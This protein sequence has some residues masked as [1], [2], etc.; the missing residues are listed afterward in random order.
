MA[1]TNPLTIRYNDSLGTKA[2]PL[3][4]ASLRLVG[5]RNGQ[6]QYLSTMGQLIDA[7][8]KTLDPASHY[9][10]RGH[11]VRPGQARL[12]HSMRVAIWLL[13]PSDG[14]FRRSSSSLQYYLTRQGR[15]VVL[16]GG[17]VTR[18]PL[19]CRLNWVPDPAPTPTRDHG[20][21]NHPPAAE[22]PQ[23]FQENKAPEEEERVSSSS[24]RIWKRTWN[25]PATQMLDEYPGEASPA[26]PA[27]A[28]STA[29][30]LSSQSEFVPA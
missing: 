4:F 13:L 17:D 2:N 7:L 25:Q 11:F 21:E 29:S 24:R 8:P 6:R 22:P 1:R 5:L 23:A 18:P 30:P 16:R 27:S 15:R 12:R 9:A 20:K 14:V 3:S 19:E 26:S 10:L 28:A